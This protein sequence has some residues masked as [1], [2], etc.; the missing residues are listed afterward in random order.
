MAAKRCHAF[1]GP[2]IAVSSTK[3]VAIEQARN[4]IVAA[5]KCK[6]AY[7]LYDFRRRTVALPTSAA[8]QTQFGMDTPHPMHHEND[9]SALFVEIG[10]HLANEFAHDV[11]LQTHVRRRI[12]PDCFQVDRQRRKLLRARRCR[13]S[14]LAEVFLDSAFQLRDTLESAV[15]TEF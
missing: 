1:A 5:H 7:R 3:A 6:R 12:A 8:W 13:C 11:L 10:D 14:G 15:P 9:L 2:A 4:H